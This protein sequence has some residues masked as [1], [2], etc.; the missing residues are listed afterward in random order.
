MVQVLP[1]SQCEGIKKYIVGLIIK[2]S[3]NPELMEKEKTYLAKLNI[4]L[5]RSSFQLYSVIFD[6]FCGATP[7]LLLRL[8][9]SPFWRHRLQLR[10]R[11]LQQKI[12]KFQKTKEFFQYFFI[13]IQIFLTK[14]VKIKSFRS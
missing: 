4:I 10:L 9:V 8:R 11:L 5:G 6:Q 14:E 2:T 3:S 12:Q 13:A 7:S 1:R